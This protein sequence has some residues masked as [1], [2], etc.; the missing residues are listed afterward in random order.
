MIGALNPEAIGKEIPKELDDADII[1][2]L[3]SSL[4]I[5]SDYCYNIEMGRALQR[6]EEGA[7]VVIPVFVRAAH[8]EGL[9]FADLQG[10]PPDGRSVSEYENRDKAWA[11]VVEGVSRTWLGGS[12]PDQMAPSFFVNEAS[13]EFEWTSSWSSEPE[14][15]IALRNSR[16]GGTRGVNPDVR[17]SRIGFACN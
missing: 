5:S 17:S 10:L 14:S 16:D 12:L 15:L 2:L 4:F 9:P 13:P 8:Y 3:I 1:L 6:H 7:A 11:I